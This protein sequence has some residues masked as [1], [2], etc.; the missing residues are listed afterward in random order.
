MDADGPGPG[1]LDLDV[2]RI[3]AAPGQRA[4][5]A[6]EREIPGARDASREESGGGLVFGVERARGHGEGLR[7][8]IGSGPERRADPA[9]L[10]V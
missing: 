7:G 10:H 8:S 2:L 9:R 1:V 6:E 4:E 5:H 3:G